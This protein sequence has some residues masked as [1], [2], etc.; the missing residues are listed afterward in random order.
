MFH[1][2]KQCDDGRPVY[3]KRGFRD[4]VLYWLIVASTMYSTYATM[5]VLYEISK[6]Q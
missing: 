2:F 6:E 5:K 1:L 4:K 3:L